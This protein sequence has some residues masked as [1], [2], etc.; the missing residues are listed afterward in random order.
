MQ[1]ETETELVQL[2]ADAARTGQVPPRC[3]LE[4]I[5][6]SNGEGVRAAY[7]AAASNQGH[8]GP[9]VQDLPVG[10]EHLAMQS[11][12]GA[13]NASGAPVEYVPY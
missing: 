6:Q 8:L 13:D 10:N 9:A 5:V 3:R 11:G 12:N 1:R 7:A 4:A 2:L